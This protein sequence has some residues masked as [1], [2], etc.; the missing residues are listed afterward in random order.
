MCCHAITIHSRAIE[1]MKMRII[2][3]WTD[4]SRRWFIMTTTWIRG[5]PSIRR[6]TPWTR[7]SWW[8]QINNSNMLSPL[9]RIKRTLWRILKASATQRMLKNSRNS[10]KMLP[11]DHNPA[12]YYHHRVEVLNHSK[13]LKNICLIYKTPHSISNFN[14][15]LQSQ[16]VIT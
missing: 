6:W 14:R 4:R 12:T 16:T 3:H 9:K 15:Q 2:I 10:C 11:W 5:A 13:T 8:N 1:R 7:D